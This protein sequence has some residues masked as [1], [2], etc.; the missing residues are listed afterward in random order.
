VRRPLLTTG[1]VAALVGASAAGY[2]KAGDI[3]TSAHVLTVSAA[4]L[5][6][7]EAGNNARLEEDANLRASTASTAMKASAVADQRNAVAAAATQEQKAATAAAAAQLT[8]A[9]QVESDR[10][11]R[12]AQRQA[13]VGRAQTDPKSVARL[14]LADHGWSSSQ[15]SCLEQLWIGESNWS[16][17]ANNTSSGAY[18]IPQALP[19]SKMASAGA[20]YR[21]N[22]VTQITWGLQYIKGSY[23]TPC[24]ALSQWESRSP[25]WY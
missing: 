21:T 10:A 15:W 17:R 3:T 20:D 8:A 1:A 2:A 24:N 25:H 11:A 5:G 12:A 4:A 22:P 6:Q 7:A 19:A 14:M 16:F 18:G 13:L 9:R 23:G